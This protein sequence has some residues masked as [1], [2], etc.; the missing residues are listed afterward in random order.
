LCVHSRKG[1]GA[2]SL[3]DWV[4]NFDIQRAAPRGPEVRRHRQ[5][6]AGDREEVCVVG[7]EEGTLREVLDNMKKKTNAEKGGN[8]CGSGIWLKVRMGL[9]AN[10]CKENPQG[11]ESRA[12]E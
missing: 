6:V 11:D 7:R 8:K 12:V 4:P 10:G 1:W 9:Q 3:S 5:I 2:S